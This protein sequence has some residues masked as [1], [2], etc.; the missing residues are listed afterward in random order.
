MK[1]RYDR[2]YATKF[3]GFRP[4]D[5]VWLSETKPKVSSLYKIAPRK[6]GPHTVVA[7]L[8]P[9]FWLLHFHNEIIKQLY[10]EDQLSF[11][12]KETDCQLHRLVP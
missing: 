8:L 9:G 7:N 12:V 4:G 3:K 11:Y 6:R 5:L 10:P 2:K 1:A